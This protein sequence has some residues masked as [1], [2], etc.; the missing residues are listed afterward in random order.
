M[1]REILTVLAAVVLGAIPMSAAAESD[2]QS[3]LERGLDRYWGERREPPSFEWRLHGLE[4]RQEV[5]LHTGF[6]LDDAF[7]D[8]TV[9]GLSYSYFLSDS[10]SAGIQLGYA[11]ERLTDLGAFLENFDEQPVQQEERAR[12]MAHATVSW[13]PFYGKLSVLGF[14]LA[15]FDLGLY[16]GIG[17]MQTTYQVYSPG[18]PQGVVN[19]GITP[20][21]ELGIGVRLHITKWIALRLDYRKTAF[22]RRSAGEEDGFAD[23]LDALSTISVGLSTL[24]PYPEDRP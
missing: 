24:I 13:L 15:H 6:V 22:L 12:L 1:K 2:E 19:D 5:A 9:P 21:I 4:G 17:A 20:S 3:A 18:E 14:K 7:R 23:S 11:M 8:F 10:L 16:G